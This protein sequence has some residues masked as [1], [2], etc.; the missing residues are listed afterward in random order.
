MLANEAKLKAKDIRDRDENPAPESQKKVKEPND[1]TDNSASDVI[2][3]AAALD[4]AKKACNDAA[5]NVKDVKLILQQP[6]QSHMNSM[7][8]IFLTKLGN[9]GKKFQRHK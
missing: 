1:K 9:H 8:T 3:N 5:K 7:Q 6:E 4:V 2:A